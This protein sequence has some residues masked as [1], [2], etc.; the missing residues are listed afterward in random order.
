MSLKSIRESYSRFLT[1]LNDAGVKI[2]ESQKA[3]LDSFILAV[4]AKMSKQKELAVK[5]TKKIVTEHLEQKYKT[6]FESLFKNLQKNA[7]LTSK[8]ASTAAR[9]DENKKVSKKV[10]NYLDLY[11]E[12][13]LPKKTIVDYGK[14]QKLEK[15]HESLRSMLLVNDAS[16]EA[17]KA[18]LAESFNND[19]KAL[20]TQIA[21][22]QVKLNESVKKS[23][24]LN[25]K[26][27]SLKAVELLE[28]KTKDLPT[29]EAR[30]IKKR[31]EGATAAEVESNFQ[32]VY[33]SVKDDMKTEAEDTE[34]TIEEEVKDII[35]AEE[36][37]KEDDILKNKPHNKHVAEGEEDVKEDDLL[38]NRPHNKHIAEGEDDLDEAE[39]DD[40]DEAEDDEINE[41]VM[42]AWVK[43]CSAIDC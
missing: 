26:L 31:L 42:A 18:E 32:K 33:E 15:I 38:K 43:R 41:S 28:S 20:E 37:V 40:L 7:E 14:M 1:V 17:K 36:D 3:D 34:T 30:Q 19:R 16:V 27:D 6:V 23:M 21:K 9:I 10:S 5:A 24:D 12:S 39:D 2:N 4:E 11:V 13:V 22:L 29:F 8:I 35:E 25:K